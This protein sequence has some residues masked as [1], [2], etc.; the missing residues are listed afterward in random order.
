MTVIIPD[1]VE[2]IV[3]GGGLFC[4]SEDRVARAVAGPWR[5]GPDDRHPLP[6]GTLRARTRPPRPTVK[7]SIYR[8]KQSVKRAFI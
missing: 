2:V 6:G 4:Q 8:A 3:H 1:G 7:Q 5:T